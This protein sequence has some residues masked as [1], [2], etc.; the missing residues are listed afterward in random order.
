MAFVLDASITACWAFADEDQPDAGVAFRRIRTEEAVVPALWWFEV[1][2][3]LVVNERRRRI[4]ESHT[5]AFLL[6]L[7]RLRI[8]VDRVPEESAVLR[9]ARACLLSVYDAAYLELAQRE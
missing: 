6:N 5:S 9:L 4:T 8:R 2:N 3:I 1:R 7:S